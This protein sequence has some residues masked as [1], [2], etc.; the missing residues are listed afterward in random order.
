LLN[1]I[2]K[3]T[4]KARKVTVSGPRGTITKDFSHAA[5]DIRV[6]K[7]A[8]KKLSGLAVRIQMW[9]GGYKQACAVKTF[10]SLIENMMV[11]VTEVSNQLSYS[12]LRNDIIRYF[13][14]YF[15]CFFLFCIVY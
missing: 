1:P 13:G 14:V 11:G 10:K 6:M 12:S 7:V 3:V 15:L 9:N 5:V 2:V 8:L 4:V